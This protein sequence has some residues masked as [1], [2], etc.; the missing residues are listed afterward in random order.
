MQFAG[1]LVGVAALVVVGLGL[2]YYG[3]SWVVGMGEAR[4]DRRSRLRVVADCS[5]PAS[6]TSPAR[7]TSW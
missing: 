3:T 5:T 4:R 2:V 7:P 6:S 1:E